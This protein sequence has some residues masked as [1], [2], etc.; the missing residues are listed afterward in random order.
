MQLPVPEVPHQPVLVGQN[1]MV[2]PVVPVITPET[3]VVVEEER[4]VTRLWEWLE[5][6]VLQRQTMVVEEVEV[7]EIPELVLQLP[8]QTEQR[9]VVL[10]VTVRMVMVPEQ[11]VAALMETQVQPE[12]VPEEVEEEITVHPVVPE[13]VVLLIMEVVEEVEQE[14]TIK[15][16]QRLEV[17]EVTEVY[18]VPAVV[19]E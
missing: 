15:I 3:P 17:M 10:E 12:P 2:V 5:E 7:P 16:L 19:E 18:M 14:I 9:M 13:A 4:L 6:P 1:I 11:V 8:V